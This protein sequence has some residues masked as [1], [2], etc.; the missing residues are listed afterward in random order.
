MQVFKG[1]AQVLFHGHGRFLNVQ[2]F[3]QCI[4]GWLLHV[5]EEG[6][7][8]VLVLHL[9]EMLGALKLLHSGLMEEVTHT[10]QSCIPEG[11]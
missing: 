5:L 3:A 11:I 8:T 6:T 4:L 1:L 9:Q 10:L 7:A 2:G